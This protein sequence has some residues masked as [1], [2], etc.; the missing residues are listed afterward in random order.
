MIKGKKIVDEKNN[1]EYIIFESALVENVNPIEYFREFS[2][3][4]YFGITHSFLKKSIEHHKLP[5]REET[6]VKYS[7]KEASENW[8]EYFNRIKNTEVP[9]NLLLAVFAS[10]KNEQEKLLKNISI[11]S[12]ILLSLIFKLWEIYGFSFSRYISEHYPNRTDENELPK[13]AY[14]NGGKIEK[15]GETNLTDGQIKQVIENRKVVISNFFDN[16][17]NW[18][19]LFLTYDSLKGKEGWKNGT[20][21]YHFISDKFGLS[22]ENVINQL[23]SKQYKLGSL[24]HIE[25]LE[26]NNV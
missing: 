24:P 1:G 19:C 23:K 6:I 21:H 5:V 2:I 18:C 22:K 15:I 4:S 13:S 11:N 16:K 25:I 8:N 17:E 14:L 12:D 26:S 9:E 10:K 7:L 3:S 20:P